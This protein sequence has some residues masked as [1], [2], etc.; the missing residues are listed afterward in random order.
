VVH[1]YNCHE[2]STS[3]SAI[4]GLSSPATTDSQSG[5]FEANNSSNS[6]RIFSTFS[7]SRPSP[8]ATLFLFPPVPHTPP[9]TLAS[10][11][12]MMR[13]R[14]RSPAAAIFRV[15]P[16]PGTPGTA[17]PFVLA[18][19]ADSSVRCGIGT[20]CLCGPVIF[21]SF[22]EPRKSSVCS[23][24]ILRSEEGGRYSL[25]YML[26]VVLKIKCGMHTTPIRQSA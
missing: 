14:N 21:R 19:F 7:A 12:G 22:A 9:T 10:D 17:R 11:S 2:L 16:L 6:S 23:V 15:K 24:S 18:K 1:F 13:S 20:V 3:P 25:T 8:P 26:L 4:N 5:Q